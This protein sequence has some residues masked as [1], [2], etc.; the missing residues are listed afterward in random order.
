MGRYTLRRILEALPVLFVVSILLFVLMNSFGDPLA[1]LS[2]EPNRPTGAQ[3]DV[4]RRQLGLDKPILTQYLYWLVGNDWT[5]IDADGDGD[6]DE[7]LY[8]TRQGILRGDL[9][10]SLVTRQPVGERI[11]ERLPNTLILMIPVYIITLVLATGLGVVAAL[12]QYSA[13]DNL[14]TTI[15]YILRSMPVF[16]I[17]L[18]MIFIF[19]VWFRQ[20]GLP[21]TPTAGMYILGEPQTPINLA[22]SMILPVMSL[23]LVSTAGY[24]RYVRASI[25]DVMNHDYVRTAR[26]K[27]ISERRVFALHV[28]KNAALPL[29]TLV[30]MDL[31]FI[32]SGAAITESIFAWPGMGRLFIESITASDFPVLM[33]ILMMV[34]I[35]VVVFQLL[36]DLVY[37]I[38]D[39]RI[40]YR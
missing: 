3:L 6:V 31:P 27:G 7:A 17:S 5:L 36:A 26:S 15:A 13:A 33:G 21:A 12:R 40:S 1:V 39:P 14:L 16:F 22:R 18:A 23:V 4:L 37:G 10:L 8:G 25:L 30:G 32:L 34:A 24:M 38:V 28:L 29:V 2:R 35:A 20:I 9:G 11:L 19:S